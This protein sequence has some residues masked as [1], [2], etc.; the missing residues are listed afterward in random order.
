MKV[1]IYN[2]RGVHICKSMLAYQKYGNHETPKAAVKSDHLV[3]EYY[4]RFERELKEQVKE[5]MQ[6]GLSEE[7]AKKQAPLN[8]EIRDMLLKWK[9]TT[10][11]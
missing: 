1:N 7:D 11:K 10:L 3:G 5:L 9:R 4:V 6:T 8:I 2:D